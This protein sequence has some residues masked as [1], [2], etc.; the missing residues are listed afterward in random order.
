MN[1]LKPKTEWITF[2][3]LMPVIDSITV[4]LMFGEKY[5]MSEMF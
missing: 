3:V 5:G 1:A 4:Y 2:V